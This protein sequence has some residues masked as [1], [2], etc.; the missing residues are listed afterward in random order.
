MI[1]EEP[2]SYSSRPTRGASLR[3][4]ER[5]FEALR[6]ETV[7][8]LAGVLSGFWGTIE[9][10]VRLEALA[11][12]DY[13]GAQDDRMAVM[14]LGHRALELAT[15]YRESI[16]RGFDAWRKPPAEAPPEDDSSL[17]L[18]SEGELE[19]HLAGQ[20][21]TELLDHQFLHPL[22]QLDE[23]MQALAA[24]L[25][26]PGRRP[27]PV[28]PQAAVAAFVGLFGAEDLTRGLRP[29]VLDEVT[30]EWRS[31]TQRV[32]E[33]EFP[34]TDLEP[35][36]EPEEGVVTTVAVGDEGD[37][38]TPQDPRKTVRIGE[39]LFQWTGWSLAAPRP[40]LALTR[41]EVPGTA[42]TDLGRVPL[43]ASAKVM[44]GS[45]PKLRFGRTYHVRVRTA[46]LAG[47]S[48]SRDDDPPEGAQLGGFTYRRFEPLEDPEILMS[49]PRTPGEQVDVVV[50]RS[51]DFDEEREHLDHNGRWLY[52]PRTSQQMAEQHGRFDRDGSDALDAGWYWDI[53]RREANTF[54]K[55]MSSEGTLED[56]G[57]P[58][59]N[60]PDTRYHEEPPSDAPWL[61]DALAREVAVRYWDGRNVVVRHAAYDGAW[62]VLAP[63]TLRLTRG[64]EDRVEV[65]D[66]S[67]SIDA[68]LAPGHRRTLHVASVPLED[69]MELF[70]QYHWALR[71]DADPEE[72]WHR[73]REGRHVLITP[74]RRIE[75][76]H[77]VRQPR[78]PLLEFLSTPR[79]A[80][81]A[82][83]ATV[84][85]SLSIGGQETSRVDL[86]ASWTDPIDDPDVGPGSSEPIEGVSP[87]S[88]VVD[89]V[90]ALSIPVVP[91]ERHTDFVELAHVHELHDTKHRVISYRPVATT[92]YAEFFRRTEVRS[93]AGQQLVLPD[94]GHGIVPE[95]VRVR[96]VDRSTSF[97]RDTDFR[98]DRDGRPVITKVQG[99][100]LGLV[101]QV[102]VSWIDQPLSRRG[103]P[104]MAIVPSSARPPAPSVRHVLPTLEWSTST[105]GR[106]VT[107]SRR[108]G[109]RV[110]L[111][112]PWWQSG[113][114]ELLGV[115]L[116]KVTG[117]GDIP[118]SL[119]GVTSQWGIDPTVTSPIHLDRPLKDTD[120]P[121]AAQVGRNLTV[122]GGGD[123]LVDVAGHEVHWDPDRDLYTC[124]LEI[125]AATAYFP[126]VRLALVRYQPH[127][128]DGLH[129]SPVTLTDFAQLAPSRSATITTHP[130]R[131]GAAKRVT[132]TVSGAGYQSRAEGLSGE[133]FARVVVERH[134]VPE[135][136]DAGWAEVSR[137]SLA[138]SPLTVSGVRRWGT[139]F[140]VPNVAGPLRFV[141]EQGDRVSTSPLPALNLPVPDRDRPVLGDVRD[142]LNPAGERIVHQ[143]VVPYPFVVD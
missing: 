126:F 113:A 70:A 123:F 87:G 32:Q 22:E 96:S 74:S 31:L 14:A 76:L 64:E 101:T 120:F 6:R 92:A 78:R 5:L 111:E 66:G 68:V 40:G 103:A 41:D 114:G 140:N 28:R 141:I 55:V 21:T 2:R 115:V 29:D 59:P 27:C 110:F 105:D 104:V 106:S 36:Q 107:S 129:L 18:M 25:G 93:F 72:L 67:S 39:S 54:A 4:P 94:L 10:Q 138:P 109:L 91:D 119:R 121:L 122:P 88:R 43:R 116:L 90:V 26:V 95:S 136:G 51:S 37:E 50:V 71:M 142:L 112:R 80:P 20:H 100:A 98:V 9:E 47:N 58:D 102:E 139:T 44:P 33:Y 8:A 124:D 57:T 89:N 53:V 125:D 16:E 128:L 24:A 99:G 69:H 30:A 86:R 65:P 38:G 130:Q 52:A 56:W 84:T 135:A 134:A 7:T 83:T 15:R 23:R 42:E 60:A 81:G 73:I 133:G 17:S 97:D 48:P 79:P 34:G 46:D 63:L 3:D 108:C 118:A 11:G 62:P 117:S 19:L 75:L 85:G 45:L 49:A 13:S 132:V 61:P 143:D 131:V 127:S 137:V 1:A 77:A 35:F 12:H 82:T